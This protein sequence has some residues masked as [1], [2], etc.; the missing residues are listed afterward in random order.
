MWHSRA[1]PSWQTILPTCCSVTKSPD[2][3]LS[4]KVQRQPQDSLL[5]L[6]ENLLTIVGIG[7]PNQRVKTVGA[8]HAEGLATLN[9][10][11]DEDEDDEELEPSSSS[12][13]GSKA[14]TARRSGRDAPA[15]AD[16]LLRG[17]DRA[18]HID[19]WKLTET[20]RCGQ[21]LV[22]FVRRLLPTEA[23]DLKAAST[24]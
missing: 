7:D 16:L 2:A 5:A 8:W 11:L 23:G 14:D 9:L 19:F 17:P 22:G 10:D 20:K 21:P 24:L 13:C 6:A 4:D 15:W 12:A 1:S 18:T 3:A